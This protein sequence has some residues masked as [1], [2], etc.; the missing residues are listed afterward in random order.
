MSLV[1]YSSCSALNTSNFSIHELRINISENAGTM[2]Y[3]MHI[4]PNLF[5]SAL[6][7]IQF[8]V[9]PVFDSC[10]YYHIFQLLVEFVLPMYLS[11]M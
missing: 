2:G 4:L 11:N 3:A 6:N 1:N 5:I 8:S 10:L 9:L 7:K